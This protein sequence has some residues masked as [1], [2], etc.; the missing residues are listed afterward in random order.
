MIVVSMAMVGVACMPATSI[1]PRAVIEGDE[2]GEGGSASS[3]EEGDTFSIGTGDPEEAGAGGAGGTGGATTG[4][5]SETIGDEGQPDGS[6]ACELSCVTSE[7]CTT[8]GDAVKGPDNYACSEGL[9][10]YL[11]CKSDGECLEA[12]NPGWTC[13][14]LTNDAVPL[15]HPPCTTAG[16]CVD[17]NS[18]LNDS[19]NWS[20][21][22]GACEHRGC[23]SDDECK[24]EHNNPHYACVKLTGDAVPTCRMTCHEA[25]DCDTPN[26]PLY[27]LNNW[28]CT[29]AGY[30]E[31]LGCGSTSECVSSLGDPGYVCH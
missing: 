8:F 14:K 15:C 11:G 3:S 26:D 7:D 19:N 27:N 21:N 24:D 18:P 13:K 20:C 28:A 22:G 16:D 30:C 9:C 4:G 12:Y 17:P 31:H 2:E 25:D 10:Q 29:S 23:T 6:M 5:G 1:N